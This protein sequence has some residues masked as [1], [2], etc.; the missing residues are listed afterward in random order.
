VSAVRSSSVTLAPISSTASPARNET[1]LHH[2]IRKP[3]VYIDGT[4]R[5]EFF[6]ASGEPQHHHEAMSDQRWKNAM[7]NEFGIL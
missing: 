5:Y 2:G 3:K 7:D 1:R 6:S 4:I